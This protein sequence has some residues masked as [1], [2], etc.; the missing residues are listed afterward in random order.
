MP[1]LKEL[2]NALDAVVDW[3]TLGVKLGVKSYQLHQI[4]YDYPHDGP[5]CKTEMLACCL[6]SGNPPTWKKVVD[7]LCRMGEHRSAHKI[8]RKHLKGTPS[9]VP[10]WVVMELLASDPL[11]LA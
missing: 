11:P 7:A 8:R 2:S 1:N 6:R 4:E 10:I 3:H 9:L 5:R